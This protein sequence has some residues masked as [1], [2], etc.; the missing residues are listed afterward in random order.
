MNIMYESFYGLNKKAFSL[1]PDPDFLYITKHHSI[2]LSLLEY[3]MTEQAGITVLSGEIGC[4]KTTLV[5]HI[6]QQK[7]DKYV[8]ADISNTHSD[9]GNL[10]H[11]VLNAFNLPHKNKDRVEAYETLTHFWKNNFKKNKKSI[12]IVDEAQNLSVEAL[13]ELR[14][15]SNTNIEN[16]QL[17]QLILV[18]QPELRVTLNKPSLRQFAQRVTMDYYLEPIKPHDIAKYIEHRLIAAGASRAIFTKEAVALV[19]IYSNGIPRLINI[20]CDIAMI[21]GFAEQQDYIDKKIIRDVA[22][23]RLKGQ[24]LPIHED[25]HEADLKNKFSTK[26]TL[27]K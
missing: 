5:R 18:G 7:S 22:R 25:E 8:V 27:V 10:L 6:L 13:E 12:L 4:G 19:A 15:L 17:V 9:M 20:I 26:P 2:A 14:L 23:D 21:Y 1:L 16:Q 3:S 11:E 24:I